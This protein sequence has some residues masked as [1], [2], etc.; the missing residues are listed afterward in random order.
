M[1][2]LETAEFKEMIFRGL[3]SQGVLKTPNVIQALRTVPREEFVLEEFRNEAYVDTPLPIGYNQ[4]ISA[5]HMVAMMCEALNLEPGN[6][7]LEIGSGSG[8]H[9]AVVAEIIAP[10]D[11]E[12][13]GHVYTLEIIPEVA[14]YAKKNLR[15]T[16]YDDRATVICADG[17][18]GYPEKAPYDKILVTASA[19]KVPPPLI[20]QLKVGGLLV[21]PVGNIYVYQQLLLVKKEKE[22]ETKTT[23]LCDVAFVPLMGEHGWKTTR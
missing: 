1:K 3:I 22:N 11:S 9:A 4:T 8:Y 19:P 15:K 2:K 17:S 20:D 16:K 7:V 14:E 18:K 6:K 12:K 21:I 10:M 5:I 23:H 13:T